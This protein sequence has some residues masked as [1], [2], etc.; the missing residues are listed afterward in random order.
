MSNNI[1]ALRLS[2]GVTQAQLAK[3]IGVAQNT[4]SY[5]ENGRY[6]IDNI[7]LQKISEYFSVSVD[8]ILG[9]SSTTHNTSSDSDLKFALWGGDAETITDAQLDEVRRFAK[10][11]AERDKEKK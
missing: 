7:S 8:Y 4:L 1:R 5:W 11:I 10:F 2:R 3:I 6:D 9:F